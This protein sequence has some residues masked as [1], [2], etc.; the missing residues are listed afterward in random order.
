MPP[1]FPSSYEEFVQ[2]EAFIALARLHVSPTILVGAV[3]QQYCSFSRD[4]A[5][6]RRV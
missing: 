5:T 2:T 1:S 6:S 4:P 3:V